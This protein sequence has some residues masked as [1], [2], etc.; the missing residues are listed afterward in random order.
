MLSDKPKQSN[1]GLRPR[2]LLNLAKAQTI[3]TFALSSPRHHDF[4]A[5]TQALRT[6]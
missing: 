1:I 5:Q 2:R 6:R 4:F 3:M